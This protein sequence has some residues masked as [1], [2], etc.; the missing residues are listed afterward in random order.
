MSALAEKPSR[1]NK[2]RTS[3]KP[4]R[5]VWREWLDSILFAVITA[6][7]IR[8][9]L[10]EAFMVPTSSME[11]TILVRDYIFMSKVHYRTKLPRTPLQLP[12]TH[13]KVW[14]TNI[15][16][17]LNWISL[18]YY[19]LPGFTKVKRGDVVVFNYPKELQYSSDVKTFWVKRCVG[20]PGDTLT[21]Q[22]AQLFAN[23]RP[24]KTQ[25]PGNTATRWLRNPIFRT[26]PFGN[27]ASKKARQSRTATW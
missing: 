2:G 11:G 9:L 17:Y 10:L 3:P 16:S 7:L 13:Q 21:E 24:W 14:G 15:P 4:P 8:W 19:R 6:T 20:L 12:L 5:S 23:G 18:P 26:V 25:L 1:V 27:M 22:Q